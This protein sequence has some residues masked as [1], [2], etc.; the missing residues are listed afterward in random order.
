MLYLPSKI[1]TTS[2]H[3]YFLTSIFLSSCSM[4]FQL[5]PFTPIS[6]LPL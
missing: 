2:D 6:M 3:R 4:P 1:V 5:L